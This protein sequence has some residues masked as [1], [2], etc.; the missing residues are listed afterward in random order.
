MA[1][2]VVGLEELVGVAA[3][4]VVV[5]EEISFYVFLRR[6]KLQLD[7]SEIAFIHSFML[8]VLVFSLLLP[9]NKKKKEFTI[10]WSQRERGA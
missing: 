8:M 6:I 10:I 7:F 2:S 9:I 5:G 1:E 3:V 4:V